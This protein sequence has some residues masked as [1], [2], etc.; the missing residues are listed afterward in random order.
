MIKICP[1]K[2]RAV[3]VALVATL[4]SLLVIQTTRAN[5]IGEQA[6]RIV[7]QIQRADY[8]GDRT[9]MQR[10][11]DDLKPFSE[12]KDIASRIRYWRG[13]AQWRRA[14]NGFND[15]VDPKE[16]EHDLK[17]ALDE[18]KIALEK[19][20]TFVDAKVGTISCLGYLAFMN[21]KD[22]AHAKEL[23]GQI[24]PLVKEATDMAPDN[25]RLIWVRGP[26]LWNTPPERG[27]GQ[28]KAIENYQ[29]GLEVCSKIKASDDVLEPSWGKPELMMS[30]AYS[31]LNTTR[32]DVNAAERCARDALEIVPYWHYVRDILLPQILAAKAKV[33]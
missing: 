17:T 13:F 29:R 21:R 18:F 6:V 19:D 22:Q 31:Y 11:Y 1:N 33:Q 28:N 2:N 25:P 14:I 9:A 3:A 32:S 24:M 7:A 12:E 27:G 8:E 4:V 15:S 20:P 23:V 10:G 26:I 5:D 16:L 30:L